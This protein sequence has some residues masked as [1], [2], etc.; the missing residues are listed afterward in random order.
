MKGYRNILIAVNGSMDVLVEG[1][2]FLSDESCRVTVVKV[3]PPNEGDLDLTGIRNIDDV[4]DG[5][6]SKAVSEIRKVARSEGVFV[7]TRL[8]EGEIHDKIAEVAKEE[9]SELII[10]GGH[11]RKGIKRFFSK[12]IVGKVIRQISCPVL[13]VAS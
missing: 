10:M 5:G 7:K 4:L 1:L 3:V 11:K 9:R 12:N 6:G 2:K 13:V 8:E